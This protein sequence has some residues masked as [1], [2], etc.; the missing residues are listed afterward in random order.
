M[1]R[2]LEIVGS[3]F[4]MAVGE[5]WKNKLRTFLSLFGVT[6]GIFCI[7]SVLATVNS[8]KSNIQNSIKSLGSNTIYIDKWDWTG[9][10]RGPNERWR[11]AKRPVVKLEEM[12]AIKLRTPSAAYTAFEINAM[13]KVEFGDNVLTNVITYGITE[14]FTDIQPVEVAYGRLFTDAEYSRGLNVAILGNQVA[15]NLFGEAEL[16]LG[17]NITINGRKQQVIGII[18]KQGSQLVGGWQ[19]DK[20]MIIPYR[21][22]ITFIDETKANPLIM[23]KGREGISGKVLQDELIG[24]MRSIRKLSPTQEDDFTVNDVNDLSTALESAFSS[25]N[26][27]GWAI[28]IL[29]FIVGIFGVANIMFVTVKERTPQIGLKKALGA[30]RR[31]ILTEFLLESAFLCIIGGLI[32]ILLV[33]I[34]AKVASKLADFPFFL[35]VDIMLLALFICIIAGIVAGILPAIRASKLDPVVAIRS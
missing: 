28:G 21:N 12:Q 24:V 7:I 25:I 10:S 17:K 1:R 11:Y 16:A 4:R 35:S 13:T 23:V 34:L 29:A 32:G 2:M 18:K 30:K 27:G 5:L 33:Y 15:E 8:L 19:F 20:A 9:G 26:I 3:S 22:I 31:V 14:Q 6:I